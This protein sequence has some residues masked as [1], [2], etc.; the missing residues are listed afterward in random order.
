[1]YEQG[2]DIAKRAIEESIYYLGRGIANFMNIFNPELIIIGGGVAE[3]G[4]IFI[5]MVRNISFK[6]AMEK[7]GENVKIIAA[8][9][10]NKAGF[11]GAISFAFEC[12]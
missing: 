2:N 10:G 12:M 11:L 9:L 7:P 8:K 3:A 1:M 4:D 6:Y 5:N